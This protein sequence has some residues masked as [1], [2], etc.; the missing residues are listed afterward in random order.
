MSF[1][2]RGSFTSTES[3]RSKKGLE[4]A[5]ISAQLTYI[6]FTRAEKRQCRLTNFP[7]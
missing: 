7:R 5:R 2:S 4:V 6:V 1:S 3:K